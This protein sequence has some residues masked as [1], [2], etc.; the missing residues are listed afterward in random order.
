M[1]LDWQQNVVYAQYLEDKWIEFHHI[2]LMYIY[3]YKIYDEIA[4]FHI[5]LICNRLI[6]LDGCQNFVSAQYL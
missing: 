2:L 1:A 6:V 4:I 3:I 5:L